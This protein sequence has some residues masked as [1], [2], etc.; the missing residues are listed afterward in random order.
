METKKTEFFVW[1]QMARQQLHSISP[2]KHR[3]TH[4]HHMHAQKQTNKKTHHL[5]VLL[6]LCAQSS[7]GYLHFFVQPGVY[8]FVQFYVCVPLYLEI[9]GTTLMRACW[10]AGPSQWTIWGPFSPLRT[11]S[12]ALLT[13]L[14][15]PSVALHQCQNEN[16]EFYHG[17]LINDWRLATGDGGGWGKM[18]KTLS[19][20]GL[21]FFS[22]LI[23]PRN[24]GSVQKN[25]KN[26]KKTL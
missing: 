7:V 18:K 20:F 3:L 4:T 5:H 22:I 2:S 21:F 19:L 25:K 14:P 6:S 8:I 11:L 1:Y 26:T 15:L 10:E 9:L 23:G 16:G 13:W 17:Q 12:Q 24:S